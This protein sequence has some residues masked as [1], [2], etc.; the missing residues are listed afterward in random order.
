M[1]QEIQGQFQQIRE[2]A[3]GQLVVI[4]VLYLLLFFVLILI[5]IYPSRR[6]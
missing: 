5:L 4:G 1:F 6:K 3:E 2:I